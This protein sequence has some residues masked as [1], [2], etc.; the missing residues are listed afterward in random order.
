[1]SERDQTITHLSQETAL[2][3]HLVTGARD[4]IAGT[5]SERTRE[6]YWKAWRGFMTWCEAHGRK[7]LPASPESI[8]AWMADLA[9]AGRAPATINSYLAAVAVAHRTAGHALDRKCPLLADTL[10]GIARAN[11]KPQ[12]QARPITGADLQAVLADLHPAL[13]AVA[14]D[15]ALL[16]LG[17]A[18]ALR[19]SEL[20]GLDWQKLGTGTG[21]LLLDERGIVVTLVQSK[22]SQAEAVTI[23]VPCPDMPAACAAISAWAA[24]ANL[25]QGEPVFRPIDKG[26][27]IAAERLTDR[28]VSRLVKTRVQ[29]YA[30][31]SGKSKAD[32][33]ALA[34]RFSGHSLRAGYATAAGAADVPSY[35]I[36]QH[37]RHKTAEMVARYVREADKW[38]KSGL[39]GVGF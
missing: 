27:R 15:A 19:R 17:W 33:A 16:A 34:E 6:A 35:R 24:R 31:A 18:A 26:G 1:M 23:V 21:F 2:P 13:S 32:A 37:T 12:R 7:S 20:I 5:R 8:A 10:K 22:T 25:Q 38:T 14:R 39:K 36:Q 30:E 3:S 11:T 29:A 9:L 28:S 4:F